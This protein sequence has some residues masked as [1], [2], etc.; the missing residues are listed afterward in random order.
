MDSLRALWVI[1]YIL[2]GI[3]FIANFF[4]KE[5]SLERDLDTD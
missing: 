2:A 1:I 5:R 4:T 3:A